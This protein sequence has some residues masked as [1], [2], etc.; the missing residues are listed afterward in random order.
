MNENPF[1]GSLE[2]PPVT[3]GLPVRKG[4]P[5][6]PPN[7]YPTLVVMA[8]LYQFGSVLLFILGGGLIVGWGAGLIVGL[9]LPTEPFVFL[10]DGLYLMIISVVMLC[11]AEGIKM[12]INIANDIHDARNF[13]ARK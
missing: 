9:D 7:H 11:S 3:H 6:L 5:P 2:A 10:I 4:V 13:L 12:M 1:S 8:S